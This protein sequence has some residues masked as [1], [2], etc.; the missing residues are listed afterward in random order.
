[1]RRSVAGSVFS[2]HICIVEASDAGQKSPTWRDDAWHFE[3]PLPESEPLERYIEALWMIV[4]PQL[5]YLKKLKQRCKVDVFCGYRSNCD[6]A[7]FE[8]SHK[9]LVLFT[10]LEVP[11][12][13][14][15]IVA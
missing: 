9:C 5:E 1:L 3:S 6:T 13:V 8:V 14:S 10:E 12:G 11:F 2:R 4:K 15:V 7:G